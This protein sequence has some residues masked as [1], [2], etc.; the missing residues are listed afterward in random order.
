MRELLEAHWDMLESNLTT[1]VNAVVRLIGDE[2][3]SKSRGAIIIL[4]MAKDASVRKSLL[5][6]MTWLVPRIPK[7]TSALLHQTMVADLCAGQYHPSRST[8]TSIHHLCANSY[9][10][11]NSDRRHQISR[12]LP[13]EHPSNCGQRDQRQRA[14]QSSPRRLPWYPQRGHKVRGE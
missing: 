5:A 10:P 4:T 8:S 9:L 11:R 12:H 3:G 14:R 6:F 1:L 2:V 13:R 7:V